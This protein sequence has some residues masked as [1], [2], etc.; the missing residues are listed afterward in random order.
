MAGRTK[1]VDDL[2]SDVRQQLSEENTSAVDTNLDIL[3]A[4]NRAQDYASNILARHYES[5]LLA[6]TTVQLQGNK[7]E[8]DIPRDA[9]EQRLEKVELRNNGTFYE[10]RRIDYRDITYYETNSRVNVPFYYCV[11]GD[12]YRLIPGPSGTYNLRVWY[13]KDPLPMVLQQGRVTLVNEAANYILLDAAGTDLTTEADQLNS[14]V[15]LLDGATGR[16]KA[17]MQIKSI[18]DNKILFKSTPTRTEVLGLPISSDLSA[19]TDNEGL[20]VT[21]EQDDYICVVSGSC[22]PFFKK[23]FSNF[24]IQYA[25]AELQ[26]KLGGNADLELRVK[27]DLQQEVERSWVGREQDL[28]VKRRNSQWE[29]SLRRWRV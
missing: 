28:R 4:L 11:V 3:P 10:L 20:P 6:Y 23:P 22:I 24:V 8:Y 25:I 21:I 1:L 16:L 15:N 17:S 2:V 29:F 26:R 7:Q 14:Y 18:D 9:M 12:K 27:E 19:L 5:P 13:A